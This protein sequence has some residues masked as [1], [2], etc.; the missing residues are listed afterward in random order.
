M[1]QSWHPESYERNAR[2]VSTYGRD[3]VALLAPLRGERILDVGCGDGVLS[4]EIAATGARVVGVDTSLPFV[5]AAR[6][7]G[8]DARHLDA[9]DLD[10][11]AAFDAAFSNA[12]LHWMAPVHGVLAAVRRA[13]VPGGRFAGE[14]GGAGNCAAILSAMRAVL[15]ARGLG[16]AEPCMF[17]TQAAFARMLETAGFAVDAL[18]LTARPTPLPTG[19]R[20]WLET[21][22]QPL[23]PRGLEHRAEVLD[24]VVTALAP[25]LEIDDDGWIADY[26]R[27]RFH[28]T[29]R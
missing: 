11:R 27:L 12:A 24:A 22:A 26:V 23:L 16:A 21:F 13:L 4:A 25:S 15:H 19:M 1:T 29:A 3:V 9:H 28:A 7:R 5:E 8:I 10:V 17:P 2:F 6:A 14:L 18:A 20:A